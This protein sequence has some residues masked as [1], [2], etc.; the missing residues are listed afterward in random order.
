MT[1]PWL[2]LGSTTPH[3]ER[4]FRTARAMSDVYA[5]RDAAAS[6]LAPK[7]PQTQGRGARRISRRSGGGATGV[8]VRH[9]VDPVRLER[10]GS[11]VL[12]LKFG[13]GCGRGGA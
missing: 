5:P 7:R 3:R 6:S 1:K 9:S 12:L 8:S 10:T 4:Q 2:S 11:F 13:V